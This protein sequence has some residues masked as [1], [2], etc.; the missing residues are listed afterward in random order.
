MIKS[1]IVLAGVAL[2]AGCVPK[3]GADAPATMVF[4]NGVVFTADEAGT[5]A[6]AAAVRDGA[7][8]RAGTRD[9][10]MRLAGEGTDVIDMKGGMLLPGFT[11]AHVHLVD[12]GD[13]LTSLS[14]HDAETVDEVLEAVKTYAAAHPELDAIIG[15]GWAL[16]LFEGGNPH[17]SM[18]DSAEAERPVVLYAADGH[19]AWVNSAALEAAGVDAATP[20]PANG[21][22]ER[23]PQTGEPTG[24]LRESAT[25][26]VDALVPPMTKESALSDLA[27]AMRFQNRMGYT[28]SI[29]ASVPPGPMA[30]AFIAAV[31]SGEA[32][33]RIELSLLPTTDFTDKAFA[34]EQIEARIDGLEARRSKIEAADPAMLKAGMVK[35]FLDGVL[36]NQTGAL[37]EPYHG[38]SAGAAYAGVLNMPPDLLRRYAVALD[39]AGFDLHMH[40]I[41]DRAVREGLDAVEA[42]VETNPPRAR[43]HHIAHIELIDPG[44]VPRFGETGA[45][46]NMQALWAYGDSYITDLTEPFLGEDRSRWLYP[47]ASLRDAGAFLVSGS[48][49]PVST[50]DPFAAMEVAVARTSPDGDTPVWRPEQRLAV[51]DML[52]ALTINGAVLMGQDDMRGSIEPGKRA[53][54][55]LVNANPLAVNPAALSEIAVVMTLLDGEP[56]YDSREASQ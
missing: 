52:K 39:S 22:V 24:A 55:V 37:L 12:G 1:P 16:P 53:D 35:I 28:A 51:A 19:N 18:L 7:I 50:S 49:W 47:F 20:D 6:E 36:E 14:V 17:K 54:L 15:S 26:L 5:I 31:E 13:T 44:D 46:A 27:A 2:L 56:V 9:D 25:Q 23:D 3:T 45:G 42:V 41:G 8:V 32:T 10:I 48:D 43:H 33:L 11:D 4:V 34:A 29:D 30:D 40:A 38:S 21:R